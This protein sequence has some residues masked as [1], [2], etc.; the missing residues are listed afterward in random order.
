MAKPLSFKDMMTVNYRPGEDE[1]TAYR[2]H[3]RRRGQ[4]AGTDAEYSSTNPP[5]K[6]TDEAL[7]IQQRMA[8]GRLMKRMKNKI[9]I[10]RD[11]A[12]RRMANKDTLERRA[13][14]AA[15]K[16]ILKKITKGQ[17]K[18]SLPFARRQELEKRLD[19]PVIKKRI[20]ML[21]KRMLKDVRRK[22]I[23]RKKG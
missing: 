2:A 22:E 20:K 10:G 23:Q 11:R 8:R 21:A 7:T 14:K 16:A 17:D 5:R 6:E 4:G 1:L 3:K 9:K 15:R 12:R 18:S 19:K 13:M